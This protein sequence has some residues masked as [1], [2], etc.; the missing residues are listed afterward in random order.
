MKLFGTSRI[1]IQDTDCNKLEV[2]LLMVCGEPFFWAK[3]ARRWES[4]ES[5]NSKFI[6]WRVGR[7][8]WQMF[9]GPGISF[10]LQ[11]TRHLREISLLVFLRAHV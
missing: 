3:R 7:D 10:G 6:G 5:P 8:S 1:A 4:S 2:S 9:I 11:Q